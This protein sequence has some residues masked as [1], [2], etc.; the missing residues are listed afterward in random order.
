MKQVRRRKIAGMAA[1]ASDMI[2]ELSGTSDDVRNFMMRKIRRSGWAVA[3]FVTVIGAA[4]AQTGNDRGYAACGSIADPAARLSCYDA[5]RAPQQPSRNPAAS[6][7]G[8]WPEFGRS[9]SSAPPPPVRPGALQSLRDRKIAANVASYLFL[10]THKFEV[11]LE[12]GQIWRQ[13]A[14]DDGTAQFRQRGGNRVVI[15]KGFWNSYDLKLNDMSAVFK[16]TRMQ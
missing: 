6:D 3:L 16:V 14:T 10:P 11:T 2:A 12:N 9:T 13:V 4:Q 7:A 5:A 15:T 8:H 1:C